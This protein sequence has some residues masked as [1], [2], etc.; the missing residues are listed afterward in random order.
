[1]NKNGF[2]FVTDY[3]NVDKREALNQRWRPLSYYKKLLPNLNYIGKIKFRND[4]SPKQLFIF[5]NNMLQENELLKGNS[6][7]KN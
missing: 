2:F 1:M 7:I 3:L 4:S 6:Y 5:K